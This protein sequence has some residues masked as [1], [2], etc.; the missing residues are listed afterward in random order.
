MVKLLVGDIVICH[1]PYD[2]N[3][4]IVGKKGFILELPKKSH[5]VVQFFDKIKE[6]HK[7]RTIK[8]KTK[9]CFSVPDN[10]FIAKPTKKQQ[11]DPFQSAKD[12]HLKQNDPVNR[13]LKYFEYRQFGK[14]KETVKS[15]E[16]HI[17]DLKKKITNVTSSLEDEKR[18]L[19]DNTKLLSSKKPITNEYVLEQLRRIRKMSDINEMFF[20]T[21]NELVMITS[22]II[23]RSEVNFGK[24]TLVFN[25]SDN[26]FVVKRLTGAVKSGG[27]RSYY[28]HLFIQ[29]NGNVCW[30]AT[31]VNMAYE[32]GQLTELVMV[33]LEIL[34]AKQSVYNG[35]PYVSRR[36]FVEGLAIG[37]IDK[38]NRYKRQGIEFDINEFLEEEECQK[39]ETK[40]KEK[41]TTKARP[42]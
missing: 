6:G 10:C 17:E 1:S 32:K 33:L 37:D 29:D 39:R 22:D 5:Y 26:R 24:Y 12:F 21:S 18:R 3:E 13:V 25:F 7:G 34:K 23:S 15:N 28:H 2:N 27:N 20:N 30:G 31:E 35:N 42:K 41:K 8:I 19:T 16:Y 40:I 14:L 4:T 38:D 9:Q 36:F 11:K